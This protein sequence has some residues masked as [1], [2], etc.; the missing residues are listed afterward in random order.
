MT[1]DQGMTGF[2][3]LKVIKSSKFLL[4]YFLKARILIADEPATVYLSAHRLRQHVNCANQKSRDNAKSYS[5][6]RVLIIYT[7]HPVECLLCK[8]LAIE[9]DLVG[10]WSASKS[11]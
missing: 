7:N 3:C 2:L 5:V 11:I 8:H 6:N 9:F 4:K 1:H 10:E